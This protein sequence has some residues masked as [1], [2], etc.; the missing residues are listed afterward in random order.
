MS[1]LSRASSP[2]SRCVFAAVSVALLLPLGACESLRKAAGI[3]KTPPDEFAVLSRAPLTLPPDYT[4]RPPQAGAFRPQESQPTELARQTVFRAG[5]A[6]GP[7][8]PGEATLSSGEVALLRQA[9]AASA[10]PDIRRQISQDSTHLNQTD[11]SFVNRLLFWKDTPIPGDAVD[12]VE[13]AKRLQ[14]SV[15]AGKAPDARAAS[16]AGAPETAASDA[17]TA[18]QTPPAPTESA[19]IERKKSSGFFWGL[20]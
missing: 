18:T 3:E 20:F 6:S 13:E 17:A 15:A 11:Q 16:A 8:I 14:E 10:S 4:L 2:F 5:E 9:G 1:P 19:T 12:P 7:P